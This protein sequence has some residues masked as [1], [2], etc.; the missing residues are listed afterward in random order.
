MEEYRRKLIISYLFLQNS[1]EDLISQIVN[2]G[3]KGV[4]KEIDDTF[5]DFDRYDFEVAQFRG[6][7]DIN[8]NILLDVYDE[9]EYAMDMILAENEITE[10][11]I[12]EVWEEWLALIDPY[13][14][15][16]VVEDYED[17]DED[18]MGFEGLGDFETWN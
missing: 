18:D 2:I 4:Y 3:M 11:E 5:S 16:D 1:Q 7:D 15:D 8:L 9:M 13:I 6:T 12:N 17:E 10:E 14:G